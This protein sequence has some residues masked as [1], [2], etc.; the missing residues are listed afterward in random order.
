MQ[1]K[2]NL[3]DRNNLVIHMGADGRYKEC[4]PNLVM[5]MLLLFPY[6]CVFFITGWLTNRAM[7]YK[8]LFLIIVH[9]Q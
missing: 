4:Y 7:E 5:L 6:F 9:E 2:I 8:Y 3:L 1:Y